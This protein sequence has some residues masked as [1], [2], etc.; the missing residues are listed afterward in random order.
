MTLK[1]IHKINL[2][3]KNHIDLGL[4]IKT[5][6]YKQKKEGSLVIEFIRKLNKSHK[7]SLFTINTCTFFCHNLRIVHICYFSLCPLPL[8][9]YRKENKRKDIITVII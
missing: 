8:F 7:W 1:I 6:Y 3:I 9:K 4:R 5:K 2:S